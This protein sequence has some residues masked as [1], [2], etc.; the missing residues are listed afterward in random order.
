M[1]TVCDFNQCAG[2]MACLEVCPKQAISIRDSLD[3]YNAEIDEASCIHCD[4]CFRVCHQNQE[5]E[6]KEPILWKQGW[7]E[8]RADHENS[9]SGGLGAEL[10]RNFLENHGKVCTCC[11]RDGEFVFD[12]VP[13]EAD[14]PRYVGSKYV[15]SN[16]VGIY[17]KIKSCLS[18]GEEVLFIGLP[19]QVAAVRRFC[20]HRLSEKLYTVDLIC[21]GTPS[22][23]LLEQ[24]LLES[25]YSLKWLQNVEFRRKSD[26]H[27]YM[28][29]QTKLPKRVQDLYTA[30]FL[31]GL[32][33]TEN[34]YSCKYARLERG[35]DLTIGDSWGSELPEEEQSKGL[36]LILCQTEK[37]RQ[38]LE[39]LHVHLEPVDLGRAAVENTQLRKPTPRP[40]ERL[41]FYNS[42]KKTSSFRIAVAVSFPK[43]SMKQW[44]KLILIKGKILKDKK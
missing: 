5:A 16:P 31:K 11:F 28:D 18:A 14:I 15:K 40:K 13:S 8:K 41:R 37:G 44:I 39:A 43:E 6:L 17:R 21:H 29:H 3:A 2:C 38:L 34:C 7:A 4:A 36:S 10:I 20:G 25:G 35:S 19:C 12:F 30:A 24:Y 32:D 22:P 42:L 1:K 23:K 9:S 27:L 26:F 33:Y